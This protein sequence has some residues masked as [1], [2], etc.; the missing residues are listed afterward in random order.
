MQNNVL[1]KYK[2][3]MQFLKEH[4]LEFYV[5][6]CNVYSAIMEKFY[7]NNFKTYINEITKLQIELYVKQDTILNE[8]PLLIKTA[9]NL[10]G[11]DKNQSGFS[12]FSL[13]EREDVLDN[14]DENPIMY[15]L[16]AHNNKKVFIEGGFKSINKVK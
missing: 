5:E 12:I 16:E 6:L 10:R 8:N 9:L 13:L 4:F 15:H 3:F 14:I 2:V 7:F 1:V 11:T